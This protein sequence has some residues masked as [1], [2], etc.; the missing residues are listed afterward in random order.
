MRVPVQVGIAGNERADFEARQPTLANIV[1]IVQCTI[2]CSG[3][4]FSREK[5][6]VGRMAEKLGCR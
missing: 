2:S 3:F 4:N 5:E 1:Y 6:N